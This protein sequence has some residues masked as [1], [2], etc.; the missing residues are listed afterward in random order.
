MLFNHRLTLSRRPVFSSTHLK[1]QSQPDSNP[2]P[3]TDGFAA[4]KRKDRLD[5]RV[6]SGMILAPLGFLLI[7]LVPSPEG[8]SIEAQRVAAVAYAMATLWICETIPIAI[9]SLLPIVLFPALGIMPTSQATAPYG[10]HLIFL[11]MGGFI[12]AL[13][14]QRF[15]RSHCGAACMR[16]LRRSK[17]LN[18]RSKRWAVPRRSPWVRSQQLLQS[19]F[20][21]SVPSCVVV[22][23]SSVWYERGRWRC[24]SDV[25]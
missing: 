11:F 21:S 12:I 5:G 25:G 24:S 23:A 10:N 15:S 3:S 22:H 18:T 7:L 20:G 17:R 8:M 9:T 4:P 2:Q 19:T 6:L 16:L 14:M 13:S 1:T